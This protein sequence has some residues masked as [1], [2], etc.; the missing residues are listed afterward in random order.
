M[1]DTA[2]SAPTRQKG[3][4][5]PVVKYHRM[6]WA[7]EYLLG[8]LP[9]PSFPIDVT[10]GLT[11]LG[12]QGNAD[13]GDC[14]DA[15]ETHLE[16]VTS[17]AAGQSPPYDPQPSDG[18]GCVSVVRYKE[19][20]GA[21]TPPGNGSD[22]ASFCLWGV[23]KGLWRAFAPADHTNLP[24]LL[25]LMQAGFGLLIGVSLTDRNEAQFNAG[26]PFTGGTPDP[27]NG[28]CV[29]LG[30]ATGP[31]GPFRVGTWGVWWEADLSFVMDCL[32]NNPDGEAF[33]LVTNEEQLARFEPAL[34]ADV[35]ELG[36][37]VPAVPPPPTP[38]APPPAPPTPP[39][40]PAP[41]G[42]GPTPLPSWW[43]EF[44]AELARYER[45]LEAWW[46]HNFGAAGP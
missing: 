30:A 40:P 43:D 38:P 5:R 44:V 31:S 28:H 17:R 29:L 15:A 35:A 4:N 37:T 13:W 39:V 20:T 25:G 6:R 11:D 8:A 19:Q 18:D 22:M 41:P 12:M 7:H 10:E 27:Q 16:M 45:D 26:Q 42:P 1:T 33:L 2:A 23:K 21:T 9:A 34:L 32:V 14:V 3:R 36:G 46:T 24:V